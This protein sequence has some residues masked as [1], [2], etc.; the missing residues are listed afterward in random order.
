MRRV[1][2]I[3]FCVLGMI[4]GIAFGE[5]VSGVRMLSWLS[6]GGEI[7]LKTPLTV[8]L[9]FLQFTIGIWCKVS[10]GG[11]IGMILFAFIGKVITGWIK[12]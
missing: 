11:V 12:L 8:D 3:V 1:M 6:I 9:S 10:I 2:I 7:G 5:A 4:V